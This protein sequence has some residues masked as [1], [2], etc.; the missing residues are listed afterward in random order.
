M[1]DAWLVGR[2]RELVAVVQRSERPTQLDITDEVD[3]LLAEAKH[4]GEPR[5]VAQLLR[6]AAV[7]RLVTHGGAESAD[8]VLEELLT[9][10]RRHG[11]TVLEAGAHALRGRRALLAGADDS[12]LSEAATALAM[13]DEDIDIDPVLGNRASKRLLSAVLVD[14]TSVLTQLG[15]YELADQVMVRVEETVQES[16]GPHE[17]TVHMI[18]RARLLIGWGLRLERVGEEDEA[19]SRY[20]IASAIAGDAELPFRESLFVREMNRPAWEQVHLLCAA[21]ALADPGAQYIPVLDSLVMSATYA[22]EVI[23]T[24]IALARCLE[25]EDRVEEAVDVLAGVREQ[26][27]GDASEPTLQLSLVREFARLSGP[28]GGDRTTSALEHYAADLEAELWSMRMSRIASLTTRREHERLA[29]E[30]GTFAVQARQDPLTGLPNRRALDE[31]LA[32]LASTPNTHPLSIAL[33]DLDGFKDVND[34][35][36]HAEGDEVLRVVAG[37]LSRALRGNDLVARYGGD[38]FVV[39][40]PGASL[41]S[42]E[43]ALNRAVQAVALLP[44]DQ[45]RGVTLSVGVVALRTHELAS[46]AVARA[47]AAMYLA[48]RRGGNSVAAVSGS[49]DMDGP[50]RPAWTAPEAT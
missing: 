47:D 50:D 22:R 34:R 40:L 1:S 28:E 4:R 13:L 26:V 33:I 38:E 27:A 8:P 20:S 45:S 17:I 44:E 21:H 18:N 46:Q 12:A 35:C 43:A 14:V 48:K 24:A 7:V 41:S 42:A 16:G 9:H 31:Q 2:A 39:L 5:M 19:A 10:T 3:R 36:S 37:T 49:A 15:V 11:L 25:R 23:V 30:H 29:R 6:A 32:G